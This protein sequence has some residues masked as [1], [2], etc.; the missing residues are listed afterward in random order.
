MDRFFLRRLRASILAQIV[1]FGNETHVSPVIWSGAQ[2]GTALIPQENHKT[3]LV[4]TSQPDT[5]GLRR[6]ISSYAYSAEIPAAVAATVYI[7]DRKITAWG[8][9]KRD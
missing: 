5:P 9:I 1:E 7:F 6:R 2:S 8:A 3:V 4:V